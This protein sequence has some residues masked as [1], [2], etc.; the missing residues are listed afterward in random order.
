MLRKVV[1]MV[2]FAQCFSVLADETTDILTVEQLSVD[3][4]VNKIREG[5]FAVCTCLRCDWE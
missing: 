2:T 3:V 5:F 4:Y 1:G